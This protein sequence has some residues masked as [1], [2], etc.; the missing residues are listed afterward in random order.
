ME[1]V[2]NHIF[3]MENVGVGEEDKVVWS[4]MATISLTSVHRV[5]IGNLIQMS[6]LVENMPTRICWHSVELNLN[7]VVVVTFDM[8]NLLGEEK[9]MKQ[10]NSIVVL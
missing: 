7:L 8:H 9:Q 5:H 1:N 10:K 2:V 6:H 4:M 3:A